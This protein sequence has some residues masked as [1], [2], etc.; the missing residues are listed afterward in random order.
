MSTMSSLPDDL[1]IALAAHLKQQSVTNNLLQFILVCKRW[2]QLGHHVLYRNVALNDTTVERFAVLF[3]AEKYGDRI[4]SLSVQLGRD[5]RDKWTDSWT[6]EI[7]LE[8]RLNSIIPVISKFKNLA[9]FSLLIEGHSTRSIP[10]ARIVALLNSSP[11]TCRNLSEVC[12][13]LRCYPAN[14][15]ATTA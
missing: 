6:F 2:Y 3:N 9:S 8:R 5:I 11:N 4:R 10:R 14:I 15:A 7:S 13:C 12:P 1:V